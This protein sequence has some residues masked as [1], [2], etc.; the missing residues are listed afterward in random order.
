MKR[1]CEK[2]RFR[3]NF[4]TDFVNM[5]GKF[6]LIINYDSQ[7]LSFGYETNFLIATI[8]KEILMDV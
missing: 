3:I 5:S 2:E 6:E 1:S 8:D 4:F 7:N